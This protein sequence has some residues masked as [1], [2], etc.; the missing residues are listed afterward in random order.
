MFPLKAACSIS[1]RLSPLRNLAL[2][3]LKLRTVGLDSLN[4]YLTLDGVWPSAERW[5]TL[6]ARL[7]RDCCSCKTRASVTAGCKSLTRCCL[8][9]AGLNWACVDVVVVVLRKKT[10]SGEVTHVPSRN[11]WRQKCRHFGDTT[12]TDTLSHS[13]LHPSSESCCWSSQAHWLVC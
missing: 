7:K 4:L 11:Y 10:Q 2:T 3:N 5:R 6:V 8:T 13:Q 12:D 9:E 1:M